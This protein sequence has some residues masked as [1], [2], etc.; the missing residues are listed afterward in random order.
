[1]VGL[2]RGQQES[3]FS[4]EQVKGREAEVEAGVDD[5]GDRSPWRLWWVDQKPFEGSEQGRDVTSLATVTS[6]PC[7]GQAWSPV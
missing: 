1:M 6:V 3:C 7:W 4:Q 2:F 5:A